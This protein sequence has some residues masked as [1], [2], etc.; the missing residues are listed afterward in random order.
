MQHF[1]VC[2]H[3][4][5]HSLV[6]LCWENNCHLGCHVLLSSVGWG[7]LLASSFLFLHIPPLPSLSL[8]FLVSNLNQMPAKPL[9]PLVK[10][11]VTPLLL[12]GPL[13]QVYAPSGSCQGPFNLNPFHFALLSVFFLYFFLSWSLFH[14]EEA[15]VFLCCTL[16][17]AFLRWCQ[18]TA[19][20]SLG[21]SSFTWK[22]IAFLYIYISLMQVQEEKGTTCCVAENQKQFK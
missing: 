17:P 11:P 22:L 3:E 13:Q 10:V 1:S 8:S 5:A 19:W 16:S 2:C 7:R 4:A 21:G 20:F 15:G 18:K 12:A 14:N 9:G 6:V